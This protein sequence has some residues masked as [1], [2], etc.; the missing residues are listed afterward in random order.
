MSEHV[1]KS[2]LAEHFG[3][4]LP[5]V[6]AW[7]RRGC[8]VVE[9]GGRGKPYIFDVEAVAEWREDRDRSRSSLDSDEMP[10]PEAW[11]G[12]D[13][14]QWDIDEAQ[15]RKE[16][17]LAQLRQLEVEERAGRLIPT[18]EVLNN[19]R[20]GL[21]KVRSKML[22]LP[23]SIAPRLGRIGNKPAVIQAE[24]QEAISAILT[25]LSDGIEDSD[26]GGLD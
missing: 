19:V 2:G 5:T 14:S 21:A 17:A 10:T 24:L 15:R 7:L 9:K 25:E 6:D 20:V 3:V 23:A 18:D 4:E 11:D 12:V 16:I 22:G 26:E 13:P 8:P 1:N